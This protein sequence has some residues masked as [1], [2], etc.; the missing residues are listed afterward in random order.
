MR[1]HMYIEIDRYNLGIEIKKNVRLSPV[2]RYVA[3]IL[4]GRKHGHE[5][6]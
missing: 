6:M 1:W 5:P 4:P 3:R 2:A